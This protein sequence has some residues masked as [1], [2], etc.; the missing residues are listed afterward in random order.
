[1]NYGTVRSCAEKLLET[2]LDIAA[3]IAAYIIFHNDDF[4]WQFLIQ[5]WDF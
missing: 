1:M 3:Q 4:L 5:F 2:T